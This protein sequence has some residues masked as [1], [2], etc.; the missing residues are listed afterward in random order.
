[1]PANPDIPR[2]DPDYLH[3]PGHRK[4]KLDS[5]GWFDWLTRTDTRSFAFT[6]HNGHFTARK[7]AKQR[8]GDYWYAYRWLDGKTAKLYLGSSHDLTRD[9]LNQVATRLSP[10]PQLALPI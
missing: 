6:G 8:G 2:A 4:I 1:M 9:R 5:K 10:E 3:C 7:E